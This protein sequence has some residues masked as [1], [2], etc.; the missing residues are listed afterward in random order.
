MRKKIGARGRKR[1]GGQLYNKGGPL[2]CHV[3]QIFIVFLLLFFGT[4]VELPGISGEWVYNTSI[5]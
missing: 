4:F 1:G 2:C 3:F 5:F